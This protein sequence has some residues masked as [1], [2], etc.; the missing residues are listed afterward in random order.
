M[1]AVIRDGQNIAQ[2]LPDGVGSTR[3][4]CCRQ[5]GRQAGRRDALL[6]IDYYNSRRDITV[7][8]GK[9]FL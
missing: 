4:I 9:E 1:T 6:V 8:T 5:A 7:A 2:Q 3:E